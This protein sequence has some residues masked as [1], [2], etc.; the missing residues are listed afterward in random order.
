[1]TPYDNV[2]AALARYVPGL[3]GDQL[4]L[5]ASIATVASGVGQAR[6]IAVAL[7]QENA[8]LWQLVECGS[9]GKPALT[10]DDRQSFLDHGAHEACVAELHRTFDA[11]LGGA[12]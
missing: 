9:C 11:A 10:E 6:D 1:M 8:R 5:A 3:T 4:T 7:E 12:R 2:Q